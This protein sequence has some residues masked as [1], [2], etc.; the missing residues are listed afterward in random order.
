MEKRL[1]RLRKWITYVKRL[2]RESEPDSHS[3]NLKSLIQVKLGQ[4]MI[5]SNGIKWNIKKLK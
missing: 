4:N 2:R 3:N 5:S 1:Q